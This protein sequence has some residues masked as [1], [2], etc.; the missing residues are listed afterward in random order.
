VKQYRADGVIVCLMSFCDVE[1]YEYPMLVK[2]LEA[3]EIPVLCLDIDQSTENS[4]QS[5]TKIQ[6]FVEMV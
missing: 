4:G 2:H 1:E 6:T 3:A 5:R